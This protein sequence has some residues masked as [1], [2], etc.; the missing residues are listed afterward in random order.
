MRHCP[1]LIEEDPPRHSCQPN[2]QGLVA[3]H[4]VA[5][6]RSRE[7]RT[8]ERGEWRRRAE[9]RVLGGEIASGSV[10]CGRHDLE[11]KLRESAADSSGIGGERRAHVHAA[12]VG[13]HD[14]DEAPQDH[15]Q[16]GAARKDGKQRL[17]EGGEF[18]VC[19]GLTGCAAAAATLLSAGSKD[20]Y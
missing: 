19:A 17:R 9:W 16:Q 1:K 11:E 8:G 6:G 10:E 2:Q 15:G 14:Q 20:G 4:G 7:R 3:G 13:L 5:H 12:G 18:V